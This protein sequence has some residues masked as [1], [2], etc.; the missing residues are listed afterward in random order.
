MRIMLCLCGAAALGAALILVPMHPRSNNVGAS[1]GVTRAAAAVGGVAS[2]DSSPSSRAV[3]AP[4]KG[5]FL[6]FDRNIY[7]GDDAMPILRKT[8]AYAGFWV[9]PPPG[10]KINTW[11]GKRE[12]MKSLGFGFAVLYRARALNEVKKDAAAKQK[13]VIDAK[14]AA[15]G[16]KSEGFAP[17]TV[18]FLDIEDGGRLPPTFHTYLRAWADELSRAG[19]RPGVYC[20]GVPNKTDENIR[21]ADDIREHMHERELVYWVFNDFCPPAPG[22]VASKTPPVSGGGV[23]YA[24][25]WQYAQSPRMKERTAKCAATYSADGNCYA[26]GDTAHAWFLDLNSANSADPSSAE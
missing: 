6:G 19:Y 14:A 15:E 21:T 23:S 3:A 10:E 26:P 5:P 2:A 16:A 7:P 22:C 25:M 4:E 11:K 8:F 24:A 20:S 1:E 18:I 17:N 9:G 13:A 12:L